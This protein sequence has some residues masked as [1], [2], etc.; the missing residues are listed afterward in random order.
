MAK[1]LA[2][3][4]TFLIAFQQASASYVSPIRETEISKEEIEAAIIKHLIINCEEKYRN[5]IEENGGP[6]A[7]IKNLLPEI[8][9]YFSIYQ[10]HQQTRDKPTAFTIKIDNLKVHPGNKDQKKFNEEVLWDTLHPSFEA[11]NDNELVYNGHQILLKLLLRSPRKT[12][13]IYEPLMKRL[14]GIHA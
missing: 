12:P 13:L 6:E 2:L 10:P 3:I 4:L 1:V 14:S 7:Y 9:T 8:E 11:R 5:H